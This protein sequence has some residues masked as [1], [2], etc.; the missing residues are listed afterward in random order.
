[1]TISTY[2]D[3]EELTTFKYLAKHTLRSIS[4]IAAMERIIQDYCANREPGETLQQSCMRRLNIKLDF[5][6]AG[7]DQIP[8]TG[9]AVIIANHPFGYIDGAI[10]E[11]LVSL[12]RPDFKILSAPFGSVDRFPARAQYI[13]PLNLQSLLREEVTEEDIK[14]LNAA[15]DYVKQGGALIMF[16]AG[17]V[18]LSDAL[19][20]GNATDREW[21]AFVAQVIAKS[22][23]TVVPIYFEGQN[24]RVFQVLTR[25]GGI[26]MLG[27]LVSREQV[28]KVGSTI[29]FRIGEQIP[30]TTLKNFKDYRVL[31]RYLRFI[32]YELKEKMTRRK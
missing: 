31:T 26:T 23:A 19:L 8:K 29:K 24:S 25:L 30:Y 9:P 15:I 17:R 18:A 16:P 22:E 14:T 3:D 6:H 2:R 7:L 11:Y 27:T 28:S 10:T 5:N 1:M 20:G 4:G 21:K 12:R 32:T 13:L